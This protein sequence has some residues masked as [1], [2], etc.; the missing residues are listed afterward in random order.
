MMSVGRTLTDVDGST[1]TDWIQSWGALPLGHAHPRVVEAAQRAIERGSTY[2][3][4]TPGEV[5]LA[6]LICSLVPSVEQVRFTSSGTEATM[7]ALRVARA[8]TGHDAVITFSGCYHG[9]S[10][11]FLATGGSG[12][13]TLGIPSSPGVPAATAAL[14][15]IARYGDI[16]S[17]EEIVAELD[18]KVAAIFIEPVAANMGV[19]VPEKSFLQGLR[20]I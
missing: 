18:G 10:D 2:G 19:V 4:P 5:D 20:D 14:T 3:A 11:P 12:L 15:R 1:Y 13:A 16:A 7:S 17:V 8:A 6:E 9:H